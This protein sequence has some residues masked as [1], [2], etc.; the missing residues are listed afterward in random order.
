M[1]M[2]YL[3]LTESIEK[4]FTRRNTHVLKGEFFLQEPYWER[5]GGW[6]IK[7]LYPPFTASQEEENQERNKDIGKPAGR[8]QHHHPAGGGEGPS[9]PHP[10]TGL[11]ACQQYRLQTAVPN[12]KWLW[13]QILPL[14]ANKG[15]YGFGPAKYVLSCVAIF[16]SDTLV[17][18]GI[19]IKG[20]VWQCSFPLNKQTFFTL[21]FLHGF[22]ISSHHQYIELEVCVALCLYR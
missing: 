9:L 16:S 21:H 20:P 19:P 12:I 13:Y 17:H 3:W 7:Q 2:K 8:D 5:K 14:W 22:C 1:L 18:L 10:S 4:I 6:I 15:G 11:W